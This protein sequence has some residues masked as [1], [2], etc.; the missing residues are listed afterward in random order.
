A[1]STDPDGDHLSYQWYHYP[2]AGSY[3]SPI[4]VTPENSAS[5]W[6]TAPKVEREEIAHFILEVTDH[7]TPAL[8][9]YRRVIVTIQPQ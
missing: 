1:G 2:E 6:V 8:T 3:L 5:V 4:D 7:G 9:S